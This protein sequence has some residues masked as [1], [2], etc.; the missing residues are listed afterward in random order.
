MFSDWLLYGR[1]GSR[2]V[3]DNPRTILSD[4]PICQRTR[5]REI[6]SC[7]PGDVA[8]LHQVRHDKLVRAVWR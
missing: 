5:S 8:M 7:R 1:I 6:V 4:W 3:E 2:D